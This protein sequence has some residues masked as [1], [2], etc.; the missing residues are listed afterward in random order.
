MSG[1]IEPQGV[2]L[3]ILYLVLILAGVYYVTRLLAKAMGARGI[4]AKGKKRAR[5]AIVDRV[6]LDKDKSILVIQYGEKEYLIGASA[7]SFSVLESSMIKHDE[8]Y[9]EDGG[10]DM[11]SKGYASNLFEFYLQKFKKTGS[12]TKEGQKHEEETF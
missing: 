3:M 2:L 12:G 1:S 10:T 7:Q 9:P 5:I 6:T 8:A 11:P 4:V